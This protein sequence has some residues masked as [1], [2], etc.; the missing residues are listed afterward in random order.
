MVINV[1]VF[2][3]QGAT[4]GL[5]D[6][7]STCVNINLIGAS[8][9]DRHGDYIYEH[10]ISG[11]PMITDPGFIAAFNEIIDKNKIDVVLTTHDTVVKVL[12]DNRDKIHAKIVAADK[13]TT[14]LCRDKDA[15]YREFVDE[16][17]IPK[18]FDHIESYPVF[19][20]PKEGQGGKGS[21]LIKSEKDIP[22]VNWSDYVI[23]E[24]LPGEEWTVDCLTDKDGKLRFVSP[25]SRSRILA[26]ISVA[27][28]NE[29][30]DAEIDYIAT[31]LNRRL[32]FLGLWWF[33]IK[34]DATGRWKVMEISTRCSGTNCLTRARGVNLPLLSVYVA[35][36]YD[37]NVCPNAYNVKMDRAFI[38]RYKI[39][40]DYDTVYFDFDDTLTIRG[41][42]N[43]QAIWFLYQ[44]RNQGKKMILLTKHAKEIYESM[45]HFAICSDIFTEVIHIKPEDKKSKYI[46]SHKAIFI[47][48]AYQERKDVHDVCGIPV[49]DV[50]MLEML[51]NWRGGG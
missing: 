25:R 24:Y 16:S 27:G 8:S 28:Q 42:I 23:S 11:V 21:Y 9:I 20:K 26:G 49:F 30:L 1:L 48:N 37:I 34:R 14:D 6:A 43:L 13:H 22:N 41:K 39:D 40:Y 35:M 18:Q 5:H 4:S 33:Q 46:N 36:G 38:A 19:I 17:F 12:V 7:L 15:F 3:A 10:Y 45:K 50:D 31:T 51:M 47:D 2:P 32:A 44:C 29:P